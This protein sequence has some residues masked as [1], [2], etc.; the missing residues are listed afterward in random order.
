[1][2]GGVRICPNNYRAAVTRLLLVP[3]AHWCARLLP[4]AAVHGRPSALQSVK[5]RLQRLSPFTSSSHDANGFAAGSND[6]AAGGSPR[7]GH[8]SKRQPRGVGLQADGRSL[9]RRDTAA[10]AA[11]AAAAGAVEASRPQ[12]SS[13]FSSDDDEEGGAEGQ[14]PEAEVASALVDQGAPPDGAAAVVAAAGTAAR[15]EAADAAADLVGGASLSFSAQLPAGEQQRR[16][17]QQLGQQLS[18]DLES[19]QQPA[20]AA[21]VAAEAVSAPHPS[22][23]VFRRCCACLLPRLPWHRALQRKRV[24]TAVQ[25]RYAC[26]LFGG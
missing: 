19:Q 5:L 6:S 18:F 8:A 15:Q 4:S 2:A 24:S 10:D 23:A 7:S 3:P 25:R 1:M 11:A 9:S 14:Q 26:A 13:N 12:L 21:R 20:Q 17:E 22:S 16:L